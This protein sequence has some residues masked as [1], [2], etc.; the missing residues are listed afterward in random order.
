MAFHSRG[1]AG[2]AASSGIN[3]DNKHRGDSGHSRPEVSLAI[4]GEQELPD[5]GGGMG[6]I[7]RSGGLEK[8]LDAGGSG[9]VIASFSI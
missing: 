5:S 3:G 2:L 9:G 6:S 8:I 4:S 1:D 7:L